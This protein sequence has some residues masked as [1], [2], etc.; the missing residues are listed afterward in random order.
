MRRIGWSPD[1]RRI[2]TTSGANI[3]LWIVRNGKESATQD[4]STGRANLDRIERDE[5][6]WSPD[7]KTLAVSW[8][9]R[10]L[11]NG[12]VWLGPAPVEIWNT[13]NGALEHLVSA[14]GNLLASTGWSSE[15]VLWDWRRGRPDAHHHPYSY[16]V[17]AVWWSPRGDLFAA[18]GED[19]QTLVVWNRRGDAPVSVIHSHR[20][21]SLG[22]EPYF[23][24]VSWSPDGTRLATSSSSTTFALWNPRSG[25]EIAEA[26]GAGRAPDRLVWSPNGRRIATMQGTL[27][28]VWDG[29]TAHQL[30]QL[31][32]PVVSC[33]DMQ[34]S[35]DS[36]LLA[37]SDSQGNRN[38]TI[39]NTETSALLQTFPTGYPSYGWSPIGTSLLLRS[40]KDD[41]LLVDLTGAERRTS[42]PVHGF[43]MAWS[44][45]GDM[46]AL[47][48]A[49]DN[50]MCLFDARSGR[51]RARFPQ[52]G[53]A[54]GDGPWSPNG[55]RL[56]TVARDRVDELALRNPSTGKLVVR[57]PAPL[58]PG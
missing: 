54:Y 29:E 26:G 39:V 35:P 19:R 28:Q 15:P 10:S 49:Q 9:S 50:S 22:A 11:S 8:T 52:A 45:Q 7:G 5:P 18:L 56:A 17:L 25:R 20:L 37:V 16:E 13:E 33:Q 47:N 41:A 2:A 51:E 30:Q 24:E 43:G 38:T 1:S 6:V 53:L 14:D 12:A 57:L 46:V 36:R 58:E 32:C 21:P 3:R 31:Y 48:D 42:F 23:Y 27:V 55:H 44:P 40:E 4:D 34:W